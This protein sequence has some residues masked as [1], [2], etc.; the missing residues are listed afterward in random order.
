MQH[1][2]KYDKTNAIMFSISG[3]GTIEFNE[4]VMMM[5]RRKKNRKEIDDIREAFKVFDR[6]GDG[7][8]TLEEIRHVMTNL[9]EKLTDEEVEE[10]IQ[11]ADTDRD[12]YISFEGW[13][14]SFIVEPLDIGG[15]E[16]RFVWL[17]ST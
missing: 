7:Y 3:N 6:D 4:F 16:D 9:G 1:F 17:V 13:L 15:W 12:G 8:L 5:A 10:M 14:M 11:E 2:K